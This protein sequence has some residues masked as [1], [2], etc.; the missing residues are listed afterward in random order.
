M[1]IWPGSLCRVVYDLNSMQHTVGTG[2]CNTQKA[3]GGQQLLSKKFVMTASCVSKV[4]LILQ[5]PSDIIQQNKP[6]AA[7]NVVARGFEEWGCTG[8]PRKFGCIIRSKNSGHLRAS[9]HVCLAVAID[10]LVLGGEKA[11]LPSLR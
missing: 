3:P 7:H 5:C 1:I 2:A 9:Y 8:I 11:F 6:A 10:N 4:P